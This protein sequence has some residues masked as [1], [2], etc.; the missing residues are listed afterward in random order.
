MNYKETIKYLD[1]ELSRL[2]KQE[3]EISNKV[4]NI[5]EAIDLAGER[6]KNVQKVDLFIGGIYII[7]RVWADGSVD[8]PVVSYW[9]A[10]GWNDVHGRCPITGSE[11]KLQ[12]LA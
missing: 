12:V 3:E 4:W 8:N 11:S 1:Q 7:R 9:T 2:Q 6:W 5:A 10:N